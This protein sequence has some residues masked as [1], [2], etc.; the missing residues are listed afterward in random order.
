MNKSKQNVLIIGGSSGLG[1]ELASTLSAT[2]HVV[3]TGRRD[4]KKEKVDFRVLDLSVR[5]R[6]ADDLDRFIA[7]LPQI[8]LFVYAAG[9][10]Q[11]GN[12]SDVSDEDIANMT[13]VG[14]L[15]PAMLLQR[16][17]K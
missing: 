4:P 13:S 5:S 12:I 16:L 3:V 8:D 11:E 14:L 15:A 7:E 1:L 6:L 2:H 10:Y 9:F 17:L